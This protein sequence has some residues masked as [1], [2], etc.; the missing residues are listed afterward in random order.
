MLEVQHQRDAYSLLIEQLLSH[1]DEW[2][3][4]R[5]SD[6]KLNG[7]VHA[8]KFTKNVELTIQ[9]KRVS[10][11]EKVTQFNVEDA[12]FAKQRAN[13]AGSR[14][15]LEEDL[16]SVIPLKNG[17]AKTMELQ[18]K[19]RS[20]PEKQREILQKHGLSAI[21]F[22]DQISQNALSD[23]EPIQLIR[24]PRSSKRR[25]ANQPTDKRPTKRVKKEPTTTL[26][27]KPKR[28][29]KGKKKDRNT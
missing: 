9:A 6:N 15:K 27:K 20:E 5:Q 18:Q 2:R 8:S 29:R 19:I 1:F 22:F 12:E 23:D 14:E 28:K 24:P 16:R 17:G 11:Q 13:F 21:S 26:E 25:R 3:N 10:F 7:K 4:R